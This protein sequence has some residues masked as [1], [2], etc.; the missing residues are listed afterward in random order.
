VTVQ[1]KIGRSATTK[2]LDERIDQYQGIADTIVQLIPRS[3]SSVIPPSP[4]LR[5]PN[6]SAKKSVRRKTMSIIDKAPSANRTGR[7]T[8]PVSRR[9]F[10]KEGKYGP[11]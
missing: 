1:S 6:D 8:F 7:Y 3:T 4:L 11:Q 5:R 10:M 9:T 2:P